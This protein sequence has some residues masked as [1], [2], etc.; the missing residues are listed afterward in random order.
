MDKKTHQ[1]W[2]MDSKKGKKAKNPRCPF[3][4]SQITLQGPRACIEEKKEKGKDKRMKDWIKITG[5]MD[6][7]RHSSSSPVSQSDNAEDLQG[8]RGV[9][10]SAQHFC[11]VQIFQFIYLFTYKAKVVLLLKI[12]FAPGAELSTHLEGLWIILVI[13]PPLFFSKKWTIHKI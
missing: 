13:I 7:R 11:C 4:D 8:N 12:I 6:W 1:N 10:P 9:K 3:L 2:G 5:D